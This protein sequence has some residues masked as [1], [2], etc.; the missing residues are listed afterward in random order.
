MGT[1][2]RDKVCL[3]PIDFAGRPY[4]SDMLRMMCTVM[5]CIDVKLECMSVPCV[6]AA[7]WVGQNSR[8]VFV[9]ME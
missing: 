8:P 4:N 7:S 6:M 9:I 1:V 5:R 3:F 2:G